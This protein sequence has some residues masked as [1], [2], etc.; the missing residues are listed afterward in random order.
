[1]LWG[2][3]VLRVVVGLVFLVNGASKVLFGGLGETSA[4]ISS[5]GI[6]A[7][8]IVALA[9]GG[10]EFVAGILLTLGVLIR[11]FA[12]LLAVEMVF[13]ILLVH[14]QNGFFAANGGYEYPLVMLAA[15]VAIAMAGEARP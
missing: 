5:A 2:I 10:L 13:A 12:V 1:M 14:L 7:A 9:V 8:G 3:V 4:A 6:P 11:P 15:L